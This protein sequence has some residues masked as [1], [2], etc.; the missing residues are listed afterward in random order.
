MIFLFQSEDGVQ[1]LFELFFQ[2][3]VLFGWKTACLDMEIETVPTFFMIKDKHDFKINR[4]RIKKGLF[5][6]AIS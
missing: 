5:S 3:A 6:L 2:A 4:K 1:R